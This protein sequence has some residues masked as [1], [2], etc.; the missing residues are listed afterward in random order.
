MPRARSLREHGSTQ[1]Y[2]HDE[3]GY[4]YR[5][6]GIQ[7][8]VLGVKL[9]HLDAWTRERRRVA[10]RYHELLA[11]TPL[12]LPREADYAESAY[13]LY[14][15]RHPRREELKKHL[16]ANKVGCAL[17]YPV[18]LH[19]QKCY[20]DLGYKAGDF[21]AAEKAARECLSLPIYPELTDAQIQRVAAVVKG[22]FQA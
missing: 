19:M 20:A 7:G 18:S 15:V 22:F 13:H 5:M 8:A 6:E 21:P 12:Q 4:N 2:Y 1:R 14:V 16:E 17:H 11:D 9:K 10:H 3:V